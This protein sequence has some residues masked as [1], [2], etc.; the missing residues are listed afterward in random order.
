MDSKA[1]RRTIAVYLAL[2]ALAVTVQFMGFAFYGY[3]PGGGF[4]ERA[5]TAWLTLDPLQAVGLALVS[6]TGFREKRRRE[7]AP[8]ADFRR[9]MGANVVFYG[10]VIMLIALLPNWFHAISS[11]PA[12]RAAQNWTIWH[13][14]NTMLPV[15]FTVEAFRLWRASDV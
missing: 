2:A 9:W 5:M 14:L 1:V 12:A 11:A 13:L 10:A 15:L 3:E 8:V 6:V 7:A 4:N